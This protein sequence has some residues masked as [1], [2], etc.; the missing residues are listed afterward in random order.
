[1]VCDSVEM[2]FEEAGDAALAVEGGHFDPAR[3][4]D[5]S[6]LVAGTAR[7]RT[8]AEEVT[9]FK[10]VGTGLQDLMVAARLLE[11]AAASGL[12]TEVDDF[13]SVKPLPSAATRR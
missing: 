8:S 1:V 7:G 4:V 6:A 11:R 5:L 13:V 2:V 9:L 12:G 3:A 10:S